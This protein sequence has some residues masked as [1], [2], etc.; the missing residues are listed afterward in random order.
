MIS[1]LT[2]EDWKVADVDRLLCNVITNE[3]RTTP[4]A[5]PRYC[6]VSNFQSFPDT[7]QNPGGI[8]KYYTV[9]LFRSAKV[10]NAYFSIVILT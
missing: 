9:R 1:L 6:Y 8:M 10:S 7:F 2:I 4:R 5:S 3:T